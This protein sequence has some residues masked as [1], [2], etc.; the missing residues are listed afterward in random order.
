MRVEFRKVSPDDYQAICDLMPD[1]EELFLIYAQGKH[2]LT[3]KQVEALVKKRME[4]TVM[5]VDGRVA[6]FVN[7][8]GY[9]DKRSV[10]IGNVVVDAS[11]RGRGFGKRLVGHMIDLAFHKYDLPRVKLHVYDRNLGALLFYNRLGFKPYNMKEKKDFKGRSVVMFSLA[12]SR[13]AVDT[14]LARTG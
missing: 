3:V 1:Q 2:P 14:A 7:F 5:L 12:L 11:L 9:R 6:G 8:Y 10:F 4:P 13:D